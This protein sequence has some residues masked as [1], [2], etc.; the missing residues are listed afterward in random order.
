MYTIKEKPEDFI[1]NEKT[2]L[3]SKS[4]GSYSYYLLT[5]RGMTTQD[6][7]KEISTS[8]GVALRDIGYAGNKDK[9]ALTSQYISIRQRQERDYSSKLVS[10]SFFGYGDKPISLGDLEGNDFEILV[11][12]VTQGRKVPFI[13]NYYDDQRFSINNKEIGKCLVLKDFAKAC[14]YLN[15]DT[16]NP[17]VSLRS[18]GTK[19]LSFYF[20]S[21]QS[22]LWNEMVSR[23]VKTT[24]HS[25]FSVPYSQ[26][27]L[28]F[29]EEKLENVKLPIFNFNISFKDATFSSIAKELLIKEGITLDHFLIKELPEL[30]TLPQTRD[31]VVDVHW[32][33]VEFSD[34][35][36]RLKFFL[37]KGSYATIVVKKMFS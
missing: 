23:Y 16:H 29:S 37:T 10:L 35:S 15:L 11:K 32:K 2:N 7:L 30:A 19:A 3:L 4:N 22:Y 14:A 25:T 21:Y 9:E 34:D 1:V 24:V 8:F 6:A 28:V 33:R 26:G 36:A 31:L 20:H 5:K 17:L 12:Q 27:E 13:E 18:L